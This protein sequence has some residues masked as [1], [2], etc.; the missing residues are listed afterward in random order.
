VPRAAPKYRRRGACWFAPASTAERFKAEYSNAIALRPWQIRAT[1]VDGAF[2]VP[3]ASSLQA[4]YGELAMPLSIMAGDGD[5][6]VSHKLAERLRAA[7]PG[8][9][10]RIIQGA[11][12]MV[13]HVAADE[14]V[15]AILDVAGAANTPAVSKEPRPNPVSPVRT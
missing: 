13:H 7:T 1:C 6:V 2:M 4:H 10:S 9:T 11:G 8:S 3:S 14:V 12:H 15:A 5:K